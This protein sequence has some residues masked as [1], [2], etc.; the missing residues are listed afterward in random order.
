MEDLGLELRAGNQSGG[1]PWELASLFGLGVP[2][3]GATAIPSPGGS[4]GSGV[5]LDPGDFAALLR[6]L[7]TVNHGRNLTVPKVL[8]S[9][10]QDATLNSVLQTP[11]LSTASNNT[12]A[13]TSLGGTSDAGTSV[14]VTPHILD[15]DRLRLAYDVSISSFVGEAADP[16]LPPPRQENLLSATVTL[17]DGFAIAVGGLEVETEGESATS[18]PLFGDI[19]LL[20]RL[21]RSTSTSRTTNRFFVFLRCSVLWHEGFRELRYWSDGARATAGLN[22]EFPVLEPRI[23]R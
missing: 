11:Y 6:A 19:P 15:G 13:T 2:E 10:H 23:I 9:N 12:V 17:P 14:T 21:F 7:R 20:G 5:V 1:R 16:A 4:G 18:V 22:P 8:V 3:L